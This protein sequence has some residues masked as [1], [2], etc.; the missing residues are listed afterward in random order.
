MFFYSILNLPTIGCVNFVPPKTTVSNNIQSYTHNSLLHWQHTNSSPSLISYYSIKCIFLYRH[1]LELIYLQ[2]K[3]WSSHSK[4]FYTIFF[5]LYTALIEKVSTRSDFTPEEVYDLVRNGKTELAKLVMQQ[6]KLQT[7]YVVAKH[8]VD[9][10]THDNVLHLAASFGYWH[11]ARY[12]LQSQLNGPSERI[13][14][15]NALNKANHT[16]LSVACTQ[17]NRDDMVLVFCKA[18]SN[19]NH[20]VRDSTCV[21]RV[22]SSGQDMCIDILHRYGAR[23]DDRS[24]ANGRTALMKAAL[25]YV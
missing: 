9:P 12:V 20:T 22:C 7:G 8:Y 19:P 17:D 25:W 16:P 18:G 3:H 23:L 5:Y 11:L 14:Y 6:L 2:I 10:I 4:N 13:K 21:M 1:F 15:T 24:E